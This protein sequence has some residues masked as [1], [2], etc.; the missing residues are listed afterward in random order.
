LAR[1]LF[2][3]WG[4]LCREARPFFKGDKIDG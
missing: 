3:Y 1:N 2:G 4:G